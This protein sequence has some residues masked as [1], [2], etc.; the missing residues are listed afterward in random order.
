MNSPMNSPAPL[1]ASP[2]TPAM[3]PSTACSPTMKHTGRYDVKPFRLTLLLVFAACAEPEPVDVRLNGLHKV[4]FSGHPCTVGVRGAWLDFTDQI[5]RVSGPKARFEIVK[6]GTES[7]PFPVS[8]FPTGRPG[9]EG[10]VVFRLTNIVRDSSDSTLRIKLSRPGTLGLGRDSDTIS[11]TVLKGAK[12]LSNVDRHVVVV[13]EPKVLTFTG[14]RLDLLRLKDPAPGDAILSV[15]RTSTR[16]RVRLTFTS[17]DNVKANVKFQFTGGEPALNVQSGYPEII[18]RE[19]PLPPGTVIITSFGSGRG[20]VSSRPRGINDCR[21]VCHAVF[22][23]NTNIELTATAAEDS[24]FLRWSRDC[25]GANPVCTINNSTGNIFRAGAE[26]VRVFRLTVTSIGNGTVT[27]GN[28]LINCGNGGSGCST[29]F[30]NSNATVTLTAL[31]G[32]GETFRRWT[33]ACNGSR[34]VTC[35]VRM[36]GTDRRVTATFTR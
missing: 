18:V 6:K 35:T 15:N 19:A 16:A 34:S 7:D 33:G 12:Y 36:D 17:T 26:F 30:Q 11:V 27:G 1:A 4:C 13:N 20:T 23:E 25:S 3:R 29:S 9:G 24:E 10:Y 2:K 28:G 32:P 31:P 22:E 5:T 8:C 14:G 21:T